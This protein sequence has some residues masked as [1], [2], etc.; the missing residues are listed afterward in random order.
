M[1]GLAGKSMVKALMMGILGLLLAMVGMDPVRG[2]PRF[3]F[4]KWSSWTVSISYP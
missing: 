2:A 4:G 3:T 1:M